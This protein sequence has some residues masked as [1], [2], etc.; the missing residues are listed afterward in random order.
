MGMVTSLASTTTATRNR[1]PFVFVEGKNSDVL[2]HLKPCKDPFERT[3]GTEVLRWCFDRGWY[4]ETA[5]CSPVFRNNHYTEEL[6]GGNELK[7]KKS[8]P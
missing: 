5:G 2:V 1:T 4:Y 8:I 7:K 3:K 6:S